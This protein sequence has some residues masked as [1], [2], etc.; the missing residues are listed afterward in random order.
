VGCHL[1]FGRCRVLTV[2]FAA[3]YG[4][5]D[6][7]VTVACASVHAHNNLSEVAKNESVSTAVYHISNRLY[8]RTI[9][10]LSTSCAKK[11]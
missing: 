4:S 9:D 11:S 6:A 10:A 7:V 5:M 8:G 3:T 2:H 1:G